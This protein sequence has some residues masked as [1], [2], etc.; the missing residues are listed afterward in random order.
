MSPY[1]R[2]VDAQPVVHRHD[3]AQAVAPTPAGHPNAERTAYR[4]VPGDDHA[5]GDL[6]ADDVK[7]AARV[8]DAQPVIAMRRSQRGC[9]RD[10]EHLGVAVP[11]GPVDA[12]PADRVVATGNR[13]EQP[14]VGGHDRARR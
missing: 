5:G 9:L 13:D 10:D 11:P 12:V 2:V 6:F 3:P 7:Q 4:H 14:P 1:L 8:L